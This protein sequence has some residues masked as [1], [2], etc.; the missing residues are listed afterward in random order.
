MIDVQNTFRSYFLF[1]NKFP[2]NTECFKVPLLWGLTK[3]FKFAFMCKFLQ[4][5]KFVPTTTMTLDQPALLDDLNLN[6][7]PG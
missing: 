2:W 4:L 7:Q 3:I 1:T 5:Y 6:P